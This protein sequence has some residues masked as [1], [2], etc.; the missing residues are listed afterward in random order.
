[1]KFVIYMEGLR[2]NNY[3]T[4]F[5]AVNR[6]TVQGEVK[7]QQLDRRKIEE[8]YDLNKIR[9]HDKKAGYT[10]L[11]SIRRFGPTFGVIIAFINASPAKS[12]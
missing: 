5:S 11:T 2:E 7:R 6:L 10:I 12:G 9:F 4:L 8:L 1:M 3:S